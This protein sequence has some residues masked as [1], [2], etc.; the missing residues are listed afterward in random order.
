MVSAS[1]APNQNLSFEG[2]YQLDWEQTRIDPVGTLFSSTDYVGAGAR[3]AVLSA[4]AAPL[5]T[6]D[7]GGGFGPL[8]PA[9]NADLAAAQLPAQ[10]AYDPDFLSVLRGTDGTPGNSGQW[11]IALRYFAE[12]LGQTEFGF[13]Y[14]NYHSRLPLVSA[15][16]S[17]RAALGGAVA[18][19]GAI[20][21]DGSQTSGAVC[22]NPLNPI[23]DPTACAAA[24][25]GIAAALAIDR[26]TDRQFRS[27]N[28]FLE[29]PKDIKLAGRELQH[30]AGCI[31]L[32]DAGGI[33]LPRRRSPAEGRADG[34]WG[35]PCPRPGC[36]E[37]VNHRQA[38]VHRRL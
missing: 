27:G 8:T 14:I 18:A 5:G 33:L 3:K 26:Y 22:R 13:Y 36:I 17:S 25:G 34:A 28:Y 6:G 31:R 21:A 35:G 10:A 16:T 38:G 12:E 15:T 7:R 24:V 2:F 32:G 20:S 11:G 1:V 23:T 4:I 19:A 30:G 29:Y 9:I 37:P